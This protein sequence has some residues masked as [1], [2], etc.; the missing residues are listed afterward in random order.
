MNL[1]VSLSTESYGPRRSAKNGWKIK[2]PP[3]R[4][5][6]RTFAWGPLHIQLDN[7]RYSE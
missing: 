4:V 3:Y 5:W 7:E 2:K 6:Y 1:T